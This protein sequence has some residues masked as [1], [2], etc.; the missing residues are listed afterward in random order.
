MSLFD[1][2]P[3][4][5]WDRGLPETARCLKLCVDEGGMVF[6]PLV[7]KTSVFGYRG[8][9]PCQSRNN[10]WASSCRWSEHRRGASVP[11]VA[12]GEP[13]SWDSRALRPSCITAAKTA[14]RSRPIHAT[15]SE[16]GAVSTASGRSGI[17]RR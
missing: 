13:A 16:G 1:D 7:A 5:V 12:V 14:S 15:M 11:S 9:L 3:V 2:R 8:A 10:S 6:L 4:R 17:P